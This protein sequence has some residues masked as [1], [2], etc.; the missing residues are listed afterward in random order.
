MIDKSLNYGRHLVENFLRRAAP[1]KTVL[2][3]GAGQGD[4]LL[5]AREIVNDAEILAIEN[6]EPYALNL[7]EKGI[8]V[9]ESNLEKDTL[10]FADESIDIIICNQI[11]EHCKE[12]WWIFHE[13]S[14][15]LKKNGRLIIGVPNLASLHNR[16]LLFVGEQ[17]TSIKNNTA[18]LR[19]FTK[20]DMVKLLHSGFPDGY[21]LVG[22]G[23]SNYYPFPPF[24]AK[25]LAVIFPNSA[26]GIFFVFEKRNEYEKGFLLYPPAERLETNFFLG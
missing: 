24:I 23:G 20:K 21:Q 25:P 26:W 22:F 8:K 18:H 7:K 10:P 19:G 5:M 3:L 15:V 1:F 16:I 14:R 9:F 11:L 2:D 6:Y 12:V 4:D 13:I 17:P